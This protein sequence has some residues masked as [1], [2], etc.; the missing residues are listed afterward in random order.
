MKTLH[1]IFALLF[2]LT[3][4]AQP[5]DHHEK[6]KQLKVAFLSDEL[7]LT[8][9]EGQ[10]F[11]P[12]FNAFEARRHELVNEQRNALRALADSTRSITE[13]DLAHALKQSKASTDALHGLTEKYAHDVTSVLGANRAAKLLLADEKFRR[14]VMREYRHRHGGGDET[15]R[16]HRKG[17]K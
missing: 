16:H 3:A 11:W 15:H 7:S 5:S 4:I 2:A 9:D 17:G 1:L 6:V 14:E 13:R 10:R 8:V 12:L